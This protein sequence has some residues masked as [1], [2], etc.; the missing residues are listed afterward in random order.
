MSLTLIVTSKSTIKTVGWEWEV[1]RVYSGLGEYV[2]AFCFYRTVVPYD[3]RWRMLLYLEVPHV[4]RAS[5]LQ[6]RPVIC[7]ICSLSLRLFS[8]SDYHSFSIFE[9]VSHLR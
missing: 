4:G 1:G 8:F 3:T 9:I 5:F 7:I 2:N 6:C